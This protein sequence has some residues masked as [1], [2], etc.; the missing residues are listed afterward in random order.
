MIGVELNYGC[1]APNCDALLVVPCDSL[2]ITGSDREQYV[3]ITSDLPTG[4]T[5]DGQGNL[6]CGSHGSAR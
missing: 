2:I 1:D 4:W 5:L 3:R 6:F